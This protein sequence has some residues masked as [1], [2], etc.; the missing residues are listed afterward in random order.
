[1]R[2]VLSNDPRM[3]FLV[4]NVTTSPTSNTDLEWST[5]LTWGLSIG[6]CLKGWRS[7]PYFLSLCSWTKLLPF[8]LFFEEK[9]GQ[10]GRY[11]L[12][13][14][15]VRTT[16]QLAS[17]TQTFYAA[18]Y[19]PGTEDYIKTRY[20]K[21]SVQNQRDYKCHVK[22][23]CINCFMKNFVKISRGHIASIYH[24]RSVKVSYVVLGLER[25]S[26]PSE[27]PRINN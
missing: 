14:I 8:L 16:P 6:F 13:F 17:S 12:R 25:A 10:I 23:Q 2:N 18:R 5:F 21:F 26:A 1:M 4:S 3:N 15:S 9:W 19:S 11:D 22:V 27:L 20:L 7:Q 24:W